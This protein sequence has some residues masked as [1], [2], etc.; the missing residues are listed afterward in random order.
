[1][2]CTACVTHPGSPR[3]ILEKSAGYTGRM[4]VSSSLTSRA[5]ERR[6]FIARRKKLVV[7]ISLERAINVLI[8]PRSHTYLPETRGN[9]S[10]LS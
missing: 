3:H 9:A 6:Q 8:S 1:M 5:E 10:P 4:R 7:K 2:L